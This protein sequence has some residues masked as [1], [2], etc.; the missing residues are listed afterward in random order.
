MDTRQVL[1]KSEKK[2]KF[3]NSKLLDDRVFMDN[4]MFFDES[5]M[6]HNIAR[7]SDGYFNQ[8][9][10]TSSKGKIVLD[11]ASGF[12]REAILAAKA[13]AACVIGIDLSRK[14]VEQ[15][16]DLAAKLGVSHNTQ[17]MVGDCENTVFPDHSFDVVICARML[18]HIDL[19]A[20]FKEIKR[21]LKPGG[22]AI[23]IEALGY[24]PLLNLY[25]RLTPEMRTNWE[26]EHILTHKDLKLAAR[27][28]KV[29]NVRYWHV[30]SM[31]AKLYPPILPIAD[32]FDR[33]VLTRIP[34]VRLLS[35]IFTFELHVT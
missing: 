29:E 3:G 32:I 12:G 27:Y 23:C 6:Q 13:G 21:I 34:G 20:G 22:K 9:V 35:W 33:Y 15:A 7:L 14:S 18:H 31:A 1:G 30:L 28:F 5:V 26:K 2:K 11:F 10:Q 24:N 8:R 25:R 4:A 16:R 19:E 17:F